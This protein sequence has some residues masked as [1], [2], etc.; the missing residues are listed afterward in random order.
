[1]ENFILIFHFLVAVFL[2]GLILVQQGKGAEAGASFGAGGSQTVFG[3]GGSWNFFSRMTAILSTIFFV[4]SVSLAVI[5]KNKTVVDA[6]LLPEMEVIPFETP[7]DTDV[8]AVERRS[9]PGS[10]IPQ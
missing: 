8:P 5:A 3:S 1:M 9:E 4:T 6:D 2:I 7:I 10:E